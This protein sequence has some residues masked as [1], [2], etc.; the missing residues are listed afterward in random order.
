VLDQDGWSKRN[1]KQEFIDFGLYLRIYNF[2]P[3]QGSVGS[4]KVTVRVALKK[5]EKVMADAKWKD[6]NYPGK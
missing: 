1:F 4:G 2:I 5:S 3:L 6:L